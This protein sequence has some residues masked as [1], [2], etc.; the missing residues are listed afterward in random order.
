MDSEALNN[1]YEPRH[2][3]HARC[4]GRRGI[5][6]ST[7]SQRRDETGWKRNAHRCLAERDTDKKKRPDSYRGSMWQGVRR[8]FS[9]PPTSLVFFR[10]TPSVNKTRPHE[11]TLNDYKYD[12]IYDYGFL[13]NILH[14]LSSAVPA[15]SIE[16]PVWVVHSSGR[17]SKC[18]CNRT[19]VYGWVY[20]CTR[21]ASS[22]K[23]KTST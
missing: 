8:V 22:S 18:V 5:N 9:H 3:Y 6:E 1:R 10:L 23:E 11:H 20:V 12:I 7:T 16:L 14:R 21:T 13:L 17:S 19:H 4:A 15:V 2:A